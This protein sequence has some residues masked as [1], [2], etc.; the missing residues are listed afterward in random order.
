MM[1]A[2]RILLRVFWMDR[3]RAKGAADREDL[4]WYPEHPPKRSEIIRWPTEW[5]LN[6]LYWI[7]LRVTGE[8]ADSALAGRLESTR[9]A[10]P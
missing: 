8:M 2:Q 7:A 1:E 3:A 5:Q 6:L 4:E 10:G 9:L